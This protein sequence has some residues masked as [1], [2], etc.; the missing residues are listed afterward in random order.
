MVTSCNTAV[1]YYNQGININTVQTKNVSTTVKIPY[2]AI[3]SPTHFT[4]PITPSWLPGNHQ[5]VLHFYN[6]VIKVSF[7]H[8]IILY[9]KF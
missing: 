7:I 3:L 8:V 5:S 9:V 6:F 2:I 1:Q 4:V